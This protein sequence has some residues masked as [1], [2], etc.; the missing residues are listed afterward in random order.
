MRQEV[1][2][3]DWGTFLGDFGERNRGRPARL[4]LVG[5]DGGA[6]GRCLEDGLPLSGVTLESEGAGAPLVEI[7]LGVEASKASRH[8]THTVR[9]VCQVARALGSDGF[10]ERLEIEDGEGG[11]TLLRF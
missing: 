1:K 4:E 7:M 9:G 10:R 8:L 6:E 3:R 11:V 2:R 5:R